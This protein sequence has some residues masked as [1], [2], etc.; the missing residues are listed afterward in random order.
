MFQ[1]SVIQ[2]RLHVQTKARC[3]HLA[4]WMLPHGVYYYDIY[5]SASAKLLPACLTIGLSADTEVRLT[6]TCM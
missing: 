3:Y 5:E 1:L 2:L 4:D 6:S